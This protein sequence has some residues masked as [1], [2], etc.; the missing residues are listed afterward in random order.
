[1]I[2]V[3]V[4]LADDHPLLLNGTKSFLKEKLYDVVATA[5]DGNDAY[6][7]ILKHQPDVAILDFDMPKLNGLEIA[8]QIKQNKIP[9]K[10]IILTLHKQEAILQEVGESIAGYLTKDTALNELEECLLK[11]MDDKEY[12]ST[13]LTQSI[14][15]DYKE[16]AVDKLTVTEVKIL[17]YL[18]QGYTS[19]QIAEELFISK[20]TVEKHRSN[21]I[22]K[23]DLP[24][25]SNALILWL[26]QNP[27]FLS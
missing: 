1:M 23:L 20:R 16:R 21:I 27:D 24:S 10:V 22:E 13:N 19:A 7:K 2:P 5:E 14:H 18:E 26:K 15:F 25:G 11:V 3:R 4:F 8:K 9:T 12:I 6:N 17:R